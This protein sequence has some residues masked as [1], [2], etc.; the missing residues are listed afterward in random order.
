M[1]WNCDFMKRGLLNIF[2]T[3]TLAL[4]KGEVKVQLIEYAVLITLFSFIIS[5]LV[6]SIFGLS[7]WALF[8]FLEAG[9][10]TFIPFMFWDKFL[11]NPEMHSPEDYLELSF[12]GLNIMQFFAGLGLLIGLTLFGYFINNI[13]FGFSC[14]LTAFFPLCFIFIRRG[15]FTEDSQYLSNGE[16]VMGF[17]PKSYGFLGILVA[18]IL[19]AFGLFNLYF[20]S[21][22]N[23]KIILS[24]VFLLFSFV[25]ICFI[26]SP[27]IM[28][29]I[30]PFEI[31]ERSGFIV[32]SIL[33]IILSSMITFFYLID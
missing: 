29:K 27:D 17:N 4:N 20:S 25:Y 18:G 30:L 9:I 19:I 3:N 10:I 31:R 28:N 33:V 1:F 16:K 6:N 14:A 2:K 32:Y 15:I 8:S 12:K 13:I 7:F 26:L 21:Y 11:D 23:F 5:S 24:F 22:D